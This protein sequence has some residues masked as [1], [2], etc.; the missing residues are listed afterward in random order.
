MSWTTRLPDGN[1]WEFP[2][3]V[4]PD[5]VTQALLEEGAYGEVPSGFFSA[6]ESGIAGVTGRLGALPDLAS[7]AITGSAE[8]Y[9]SGVRS[10]EEA[11]R[12][13][14]RLLPMPTSFADLQEAWTE[15]GAKNILGTA[16]SYVTETAGKSAPYLVPQFAATKLGIPLLSRFSK[17]IGNLVGPKARPGTRMLTKTALGAAS[18][19]P[20]YVADNMSRQVQA[21]AATAEDL[22]LLNATLAGAGSS[23]AEQMFV[24]VLGGQGRALQRNAAQSLKDWLPKRLAEGLLEAPVEVVQQTLERL[25]AGESISP[26]DEGYMREVVE[27]AVGGATVGTV[28]AGG[29]SINEARQR[30]KL[31][32]A[33]KKAEPKEKE[34][35]ESELEKA[36]KTQMGL[37]EQAAR[38]QGQDALR[39]WQLGFREA[40]D[41]GDLEKQAAY[42]RLEAEIETTKDDVIAAAQARNIK[43]DDDGFRAFTSRTLNHLDEDGKRVQGKRHLDDLDAQEM[44]LVYNT[45]TA[46]PVRYG[47]AQVEQSL[48]MFSDEEYQTALAYHESKRKRKP[49]KKAKAKKGEAK[50]EATY[51][52]GVTLQS[53]RQSLGFFTG[54]D[55][56]NNDIANQIL[57]R[58]KS[59]RDVVRKGK[60]LVFREKR[61][62]EDQ[63]SKMLNDAIDKGQLTT[64]IIERTLSRTNPRLINEVKNDMLARGDVSKVN[65]RYVP[66]INR[67]G[68]IVGVVD[69]E[70]FNGWLIR[71]PVDK[72]IIGGARNRNEAREKRNKIRD[73]SNRWDLFVDGELYQ[74]YATKHAQKSATTALRRIKKSNPGV[75]ASIKQRVGVVSPVAEKMFSVFERTRGP[76]G[77]EGKRDNE[78]FDSRV[79]AEEAKGKLIVGLSGLNPRQDRVE[80]AKVTESA[81]ID[82]D[83]ERRRRE[84]EPTQSEIERR[85]TV[86]SLLEDSLSAAGLNDIRLALVDRLSVAAAEG[87]FDTNRIINLAIGRVDPNLSYE[88]QAKELGRVMDHELM[89]GLVNLDLLAE[90]ELEMLANYGLRTMDPDNPGFSLVETQMDMH[91]KLADAMGD[92][93]HL[94]SEKDAREEGMAQGYRH[95]NAAKDKDPDAPV[96]VMEKINTFFDRLGNHLAGYGFRSAED[97]FDAIRAG[98]VGLRKRGVVRNLRIANELND[99]IVDTAN[100]SMRADKG[101]SL[102]P[103]ELDSLDD[104]ATVKYALGPESIQPWTWTSAPWDSPESA[105]AEFKID[106]PGREDPKS[107]EVEVFAS[108]KSRFGKGWGVIFGGTDANGE[109]TMDQDPDVGVGGALKVFATTI[110][111]VSSFID[112][113]EEAGSRPNSFSMSAFGRGRV[114]LYSNLLRLSGKKL[115]YKISKDFSN[116]SE[117]G[118][119]GFWVLLDESIDGVLG[120]PDQDIVGSDSESFL[121][122]AKRKL[123][124]KISGK[125]AKYSIDAQMTA[126][127]N[128]PTIEYSGAGDIPLIVRPKPRARYSLDLKAAVPT[129]FYS[130]LERVIRDY[131]GTHFNRQQ[132]GDIIEG[133]GDWAK[134]L[135]EEAIWSGLDIYVDAKTAKSFTKEELLDFIGSQKARIYVE[136]RSG[137]TKERPDV[138]EWVENDDLSGYYENTL[139]SAEDDWLASEKDIVAMSSEEAVK[140]ILG[141]APFA[142]IGKYY[143]PATGQSFEAGNLSGYLDGLK[144]QG[145][146]TGTEEDLLPFAS[147]AAGQARA[148]LKTYHT[149]DT[150]SDRASSRLIYYVAIQKYGYSLEQDGFGPLSKSDRSEVEEVAGYDWFSDLG[151]NVL[152]EDAE[153]NEFGIYGDRYRDR[154]PTKLAPNFTTQEAARKYVGE[155][156]LPDFINEISHLDMFEMNRDAIYESAN[157]SIDEYMEQ[158]EGH[159]DGYGELYPSYILEHESGSAEDMAKA[160]GFETFL[161][162]G[163]PFGSRPLDADNY[164]DEFYKTIKDKLEAR[165]QSISYPDQHYSHP[166]LQV[167]AHF[168]LTARRTDD[169]QSVTFADEFQLDFAAKMMREE[170]LYYGKTAKEGVKRGDVRPGLQQRTEDTLAGLPNNQL[171]EYPFSNGSF[172]GLKALIQKAVNNGDRYVA[173]PTGISF[174]SKYPSDLKEVLSRIDYQSIS[175]STV[176]VSLVGIGGDIIHDMNVSK[177]SG[178]ILDSSSKI[179]NMTT[180]PELAADEKLNWVNVPLERVIGGGT[181]R[182]II[183]TA[184]EV[185]TSTD[186]DIKSLVGNDMVIGDDRLANVYDKSHHN[187]LRDLGKR[188]NK[189]V[190]LIKVKRFDEAVGYRLARGRHPLRES[191]SYQDQTSLA[192]EKAFKDWTGD[193]G[194]DFEGAMKELDFSKEPI[195]PLQHEISGF[196]TWWLNR[197]KQTSEDRRIEGMTVIRLRGLIGEYVRQSVNSRSAEVF[198]REKLSPGSRSS[199]RIVE[200]IK[201]TARD[202]RSSFSY[203]ESYIRD[204]ERQSSQGDLI[205]NFVNFLNELGGFE[206]EREEYGDI[207]IVPASKYEVVWG[208]NV[209]DLKVGKKDFKDE[210]FST[211]NTRY[212]IAPSSMPYELQ[213]DTPSSGAMQVNVNPDQDT[214]AKIVADS[215]RYSGDPKSNEAV[216][217]PPSINMVSDSDDNVYAW[218]R[219]A[220]TIRS[221]RNALSTEHGSVFRSANQPGYIQG[222]NIANLPPKTKLSQSDIPD[223]INVKHSIYLPKGIAS[224]VFEDS[225][226]RIDTNRDIS[227]LDEWMTVT[228]NGN[229]KAIGLIKLSLDAGEVESFLAD[230]LELGELEHVPGGSVRK[231]FDLGDGRVVKV[232]THPRG[233]EQNQASGFGDQQILGKFVPEMYER[234][235]DYVVFEK[236]PRNDKAVRQF[237][238]PLTGFSPRDFDRK[239][240]ELQDTMRSMGV[241][242][243]MNYDLLWNDFISAR[244]WGQRADGSFALVDEGALVSHVHST[245]KIDD[246]AIKD[247]DKVKRARRAKDWKVKG[248]TKYSFKIEDTIRFPE[249]LNVDS[250]GTARPGE[251]TPV[252]ELMGMEDYDSVTFHQIGSSLGPYSDYNIKEIFNTTKMSLPWKMGGETGDLYITRVGT[253]AGEVFKE[254]QSSNDIALSTDKDVLLPDYL[255]YVLQSLYPKINSR[256]SGGVISTIRKSDISDTLM[257]F[258]QAERPKLSLAP[259]PRAEASAVG[260]VKSKNRHGATV[261]EIEEGGERLKGHIAGEEMTGMG[262]GGEVFRTTGIERGTFFDVSNTSL[263]PEHRGRGVYQEAIQRVANQYDHGVVVQKYQASPRLQ[264]SLRKMPNAIENADS[265][266]I[267]P[268]EAP[269][270]RAE[271]GVIETVQQMDPNMNDNGTI[272]RINENA[273]ERNKQI[274]RGEIKGQ[275]LSENQKKKYSL[276]AGQP[277]FGGSLPSILAKIVTL[278]KDQTLFEKVSTFMN[279]ENRSDF[280]MGLRM[281]AV[282]QYEKA[283]WMDQEVAKKTGN[284]AYLMA[285]VSSMSSALN[286]DKVRGMFTYALEKG[287]PVLRRGI[288]NGVEY[289]WVTMEPFEIR[290]PDGSMGKGGIR[291]ILTPLFA[292][293]QNLY[294][295]WSGFMIARREHRFASIGKETRTT[296]EERAEIF[297]EVGYDPDTKSWRGSKYPNIELVANNY[298][299]WNDKFVEFM[300]DTGVFSRTEADVFKS[301]SDYI[302]FYRQFDGESNIELDE[303][304]SGIIGEEQDANG[305]RRKAS[306]PMMFHALAGVQGPKAAKGGETKVDDPL[307]N[308][309]QNAFAGLQAGAKNLASQKVMDQALELELAEPSDTQGD[310][311]HTLRRDGV[312]THYKVHDH[313]VFEV[314]SGVMDGR[315]PWLDMLAIP[316]Q[317][318]RELITRSPDFLAANLLRDTG[319]AWVTSGADFTPFV[320]ALNNMFSGDEDPRWEAL[321]RA[322]LASGFENMNNPEDFRKHINKQWKREGLGNDEASDTWKVFDKI[323]TGSGKLSTRSDMSVRME[324][325]EDVVNR[326]ESE[327]IHD[328]AIIEAEAD[329]QASE[330]MNFGRRGSSPL[331]RILTALVPFTGA[332]I[333][334]LDVL[335]RSVRGRYGTDYAAVQSGAALMR[336]KQRAL[337]VLSLTGMYWLLMHDDDDYTGATD[338]V[339]DMNVIIPSSMVPGDEPLKLPKPFE[340]GFLLITV[341]EAF[342]TWMFD[343]EDNRRAMGTLKRGLLATLPFNPIPQAG[344]PMLEAI[345]NHSFWTDRNIVPEHQLGLN[346]ALQYSRATGEFSRLLGATF[347]A[348]PAKIE[349]VIRG[350]TGTLGSYGLFLVDEATRS[351]SDFPSRPPLELS[352]FPM[353]RRFFGKPGGGNRGDL[354]RFYDLRKA[355]HRA[356]DSWRKLRREGRHDEAKKLKEDRQGIFKTRSR[357]LSMDRR[358]SALRKKMERIYLSKDLPEEKARK[359]ESNRQSLE[360]ALRDL[361]KLRKESDLPMFQ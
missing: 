206:A 164:T 177:S 265:I 37:D 139:Y 319:S 313:L 167:L 236:V 244:N 303:V 39:R 213:I 230:K 183:E 56:F 100:V 117:G 243:F 226:T 287:V 157:E 172:I 278:K 65:N 29:F 350:Y 309:L 249:E 268:S 30:K 220:G 13:E 246:W 255:Y 351:M 329:F 306:P 204:D 26:S 151:P 353:F 63:Y 97:V 93:G 141:Q 118:T 281:K 331:Y 203:G 344:K 224:Q 71:D 323:W 34:L 35:R 355:S 148:S 98:E 68:E 242:E 334:G 252:N 10:L 214:L 293:N 102:T 60:R 179:P 83:I 67:E 49:K 188:L 150:Q 289:S 165:Q 185:D 76:S 69:V 279:K 42:E 107:I 300:V 169:N 119:M 222:N 199:Y 106:V 153:Y 181:A 17:P 198:S 158:I 221:V 122:S 9:A 125:K 189:K 320:G 207:S 41:T 147:E 14:R 241:D 270:P 166:S 356:L 256:R 54:S 130:N 77:Q 310:S 245:S 333:Q 110:D 15:G 212:S 288:V 19:L 209:Q 336:F 358:V 50:E 51:S 18:M 48:P 259:T 215:E 260:V 128:P 64:A 43:V 301:Y 25:Q 228:T 176:R 254:R 24:M 276:A 328:R 94:I 201:G 327:G 4:S 178:L 219:N 233:L 152:V 22:S 271:G 6:V 196:H 283:G 217:S 208:M 146:F 186:G 57:T 109:M 171:V 231:V 81:R 280:L 248:K 131:K 82:K 263:I 123:S 45:L 308:I 284:D 275:K 210:L 96:A 173:F 140:G 11:E 341:P 182:R 84:A 2:D 124:S 21:G 261:F 136:S 8:D 99:S 229:S 299:A 337:M 264:A 145:I 142:L 23:F 193:P 190:E 349:H 262:T 305:V 200:E 104:E 27:A 170:R 108:G 61:Y 338:A 52:K 115:G 184:G 127:G 317:F 95:Y 74:T 116:I 161:V 80:Q 321:E 113:K 156:L 339:R 32:E 247:W 197:A 86:L 180:T 302:P 120:L 78:Y 359:L 105:K 294:T 40:Q 85:E 20:V 28:Y 46:M 211:F 132:I 195:T 58:M 295:L 162:L 33:Y 175:P 3:E 257:D 304:I 192:M 144:E 159:D 112:V 354:E 174:N 360:S 135:K 155:K 12:A 138:D 361:D 322:G 342:L 1:V 227:T 343:D 290:M 101:E 232:A 47:A 273:T 168:L 53:I 91:Q 103:D 191:R 55:K 44:H 216:D 187:A 237:L 311:S 92:A 272:K 282:N 234:G 218:P 285:A 137:E 335:Y 340:V 325:W 7:A 16:G 154:W 347:G 274:A 239:G 315:M 357:V 129:N 291:T 133:K 126:S 75:K 31:Q 253:R 296:P 277:N 332:H 121:R 143:D 111:I 326:M 194:A 62:T 70:E 89:H 202:A 267:P 149:E 286:S 269:T 87:S 205:V 330:T 292:R 225:I 38:D 240:P 324:V 238:K 297:K 314:L 163:E 235:I 312:D 88:E 345:A 266:R 90:E 134:S 250:D 5:Q 307:E 160:N 66:K 318:L 79:R 346:P 114:R 258:F 223:R 36:W 298:Q 59:R 348:S 251:V 316:S 352:D 73:D 72:S